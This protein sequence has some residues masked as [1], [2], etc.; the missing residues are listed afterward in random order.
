MAVGWGAAS[1][2]PAVPTVCTV[3][4]TTVT[5]CKDASLNQIPVPSPLSILYEYGVPLFRSLA[6]RYRPGT[7]VREDTFSSVL[8]PPE[9]GVCVRINLGGGGGEVYC[10]ARSSGAKYG[11][12]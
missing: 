11:G 10:S 6:T 8:C 5:H 7:I 12:T 2:I 1:S 4:R 9:H 3:L